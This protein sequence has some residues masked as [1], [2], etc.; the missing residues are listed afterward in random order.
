MIE[1]IIVNYFKNPLQNIDINLEKSKFTKV[2]IIKNNDDNDDNE[3]SENE[4]NIN[5]YY[6]NCLSKEKIDNKIEILILKNINIDISK[7]NIQF[8]SLKLLSLK[9]STLIF[10]LKT[11]FCDLETL[12]EIK[13]KGDL[14]N[15]KMNLSN[16][17]ENNF[18][19]NI[20]CITLKFFP[21]SS[22]V[23]LF[24]LLNSLNLY[25]QDIKSLNIYFKGILSN[26][27]IKEKI[28]NEIFS[29]I[30]K[31]FIFALNKL[32]IESCKILK[33]DLIDKLNNLQELYLNENIEC[34]L[35]NK[36]KLFPIIDNCEDININFN[37]Y[38]INKLSKINLSIC[39]Y[40]RNKNKLILYG[41]ANMSFYNSNNKEL[42][43]NIINNNHKGK[44]M[45]LSLCNF[46]LEN[47][48]YLNDILQKSI[49]IVDN[50]YIKNLNI[51][52]EFIDIIKS[53][54]L[55]NCYKI[56]LENI[57][58]NEGEEENNFYEIINGYKL[59]K[60]LKLISL[61]DISKYKIILCNENLKS[62]YLEEIY[63]INYNFLKEVVV[64][65]RKNKL[66]KISL[67]N[68]EVNED[69]DKNDLIDII[70]G[71]RNNI[72]KLKLVGENFNF[73]YQAIQDKKI[74]FNCLQKLI[75]N[76]D[77]E[78]DDDKG[79]DLVSNDEDKIF[80]LER[81]KNLLN[82]KFIEKIDLQM[83]NITY[84]I[85]QKIF[86]IYNNLKEIL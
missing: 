21:K 9:N 60:T 1:E 32:N 7:S 46:D 69:E 45:A 30:R 4:D 34:N 57:I 39:E 74:E 68:L 28:N 11:E 37:L 49:N 47:I 40:N 8:K 81:N 23:N 15:V 84:K 41:E 72:K 19:G 61:E 17:K 56:A 5:K 2:L 70:L 85:K 86:G 50:L 48:S 54:N 62:L 20:K 25:L 77:K 35:S 22:N 27:D 65:N 10:P 53:K 43:L 36:L 31:I 13:I 6:F 29:K 3:S 59:I 83:L 33:E 79:N 14:K 63:D 55:F 78:N 44:L 58:F 38:D 67:K 64:N 76:I 82:Y 42:L 16:L 52:Q 51:N 71:I 75:L 80:F 18:L 73:F 26:L 66:D 12:N 24:K